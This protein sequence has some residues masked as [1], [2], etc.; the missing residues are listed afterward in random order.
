MVI[1]EML[2]RVVIEFSSSK[3]DVTHR[4][5]YR[6][7]LSYEMFVQKQNTPLDGE[8]PKESKYVIYSNIPCFFAEI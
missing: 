1:Y 3:S 5:F 8:I 4:C 7:I 6:K 2:A